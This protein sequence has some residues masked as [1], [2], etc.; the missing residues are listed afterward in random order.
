MRLIPLILIA[1]GLSGCAR[2]TDKTSPCFGQNGAPVVSRNAVS[3]FSFS[4]KS[5]VL[6]KDCLFVPVMQE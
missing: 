4:S 6:A 1:L 2:Y 3:P 5:E